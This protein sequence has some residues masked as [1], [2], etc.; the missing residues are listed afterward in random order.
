MKSS[1]RANQIEP[2]HSTGVAYQR[3]GL[4]FVAPRWTDR[5]RAARPVVV[6]VAGLMVRFPHPLPERERE[7]ETKKVLRPSPT[8]HLKC[9]IKARQCRPTSPTN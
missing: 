5:E 8:Y 6:V 4:V 3:A 9:R 1:T 7:R 2:A